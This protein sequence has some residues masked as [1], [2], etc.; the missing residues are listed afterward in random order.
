MAAMVH[1]LPVEARRRALVHLAMDEVLPWELWRNDLDVAEVRRASGGLT[2]NLRSGLDASLREFL[3]TADPCTG[4]AATYM[5]QA[6]VLAVLD[7][8]ASL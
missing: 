5:V 8:D 7:H 4:L 3:A 6:L 2:S 1:R